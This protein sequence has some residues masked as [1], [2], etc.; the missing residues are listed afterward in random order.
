MAPIR[1]EFIRSL[2]SKYIWWKTPDEAAATPKRVI[3]QVMNIGDYSDVQALA[4]QVGDAVL[5]DVLIHAEVGQFT[6][7][8]WAYWH[9]RLGLAAPDAVPPMPSRRLA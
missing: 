6:P 1:D 3:A 5:T 9:Y 2:A 4:A 8:S 7:R